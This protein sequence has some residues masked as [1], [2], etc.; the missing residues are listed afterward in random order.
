[1]IG[2]QNNHQ[3]VAK[4]YY[5]AKFLK[6]SSH[7]GTGSTSSIASISD[8]PSVQLDIRLNQLRASFEF[9]FHSNSAAKD[10]PEPEIVPVRNLVTSGQPKDR[11]FSVFLAKFHGGNC[12]FRFVHHPQ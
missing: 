3:P 7:L 11:Y 8:G 5:T 12:F 2:R 1:M 10:W 9:K 4:T 6:I